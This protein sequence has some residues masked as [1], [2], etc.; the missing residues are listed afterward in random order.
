MRQASGD[1]WKENRKEQRVPA[2][3]SGQTRVKDI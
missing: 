2:E 1:G 3:G